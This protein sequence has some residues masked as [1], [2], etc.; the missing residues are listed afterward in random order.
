VQFE[1]DLDRILYTVLY[2]D[3]IRFLRFEN[4]AVLAQFSLLGSKNCVLK[5]LF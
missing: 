3:I 4:Q 5:A 2:T 1:Y